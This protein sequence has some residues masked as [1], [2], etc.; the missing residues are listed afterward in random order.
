MGSDLTDNDNVILVDLLRE[1]IRI[2]PAA[3]SITH[4]SGQGGAEL[5][6]G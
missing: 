4:N 6:V 5:D 3:L 2:P 1:T